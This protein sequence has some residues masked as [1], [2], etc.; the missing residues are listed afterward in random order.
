MIDKNYTVLIVDDEFPIRQSFSDYFEDNLWDVLTADNGEEALELLIHKSPDCAVVD[1]RMGV[2]DGEEF[3]KKAHILQPKLVFLICTG[4][5]EYEMSVEL[6]NTAY[7]FKQKVM[8]PVTN[9]EFLEKQLVHL[10][11]NAV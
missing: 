3:I 11:E 6:S 9:L 1:L 5:P 4:S 10:I 2:M 7:V 8:K